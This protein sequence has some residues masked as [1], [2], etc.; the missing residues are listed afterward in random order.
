MHYTSKDPTNFC[1]IVFVGNILIKSEISLVVQKNITLK[2]VRTFQ[3]VFCHNN[4]LDNI[5]KNER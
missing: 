4:I 1:F 2:D 3:N 5:R